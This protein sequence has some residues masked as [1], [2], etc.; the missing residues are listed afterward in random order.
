ML[1]ETVKREGE[2]GGVEE[3][4]G[5][6]ERESRARAGS[7][8]LSAKLKDERDARDESLLATGDTLLLKK[9]M[10]EG[11]ARG[12]EGEEGESRTMR[13]TRK[14]EEESGEDRGEGRGG[15]GAK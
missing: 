3:I 13:Q 11:G 14:E 2:E 6:L 8:E 15:G 7:G 12:E 9:R 1:K 10:G 5:R 4:E